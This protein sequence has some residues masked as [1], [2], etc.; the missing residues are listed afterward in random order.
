MAWDYKALPSNTGLD[1]TG[2]FLVRGVKIF[3]SFKDESGAELVTVEAT[4]EDAI[5]NAEPEFLSEYVETARL[6]FGEQLSHFLNYDSGVRQPV[7][8][9]H[10]TQITQL[11]RESIDFINKLYLS[12]DN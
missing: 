1:A 4:I 2:Q 12:K 7:A 11:L 9:S 6:V 3:K 8:A 5:Q 10:A